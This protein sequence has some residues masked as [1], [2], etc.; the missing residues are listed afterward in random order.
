MKKFLKSRR[1]LALLLCIVVTA[2]AIIQF[3]LL[4]TAAAFPFIFGVVT[5]DGT[6]GAAAAIPAHGSRH[7]Q[8]IGPVRVSIPLT[9]VTN[10]IYQAIPVKKGWKLHGCMWK[11]VTAGA[12]TTIALDFGITGIVATGLD[13]AVDGKSV[14]GTIGFS[15]P[16]DT[17]PALGG[18]NVIADDT[19]DILLNT[20]TAMT[21]APVFDLWL[22][23]EDVDADYTV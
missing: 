1:G 14:A 15:T 7:I 13:A 10:D 9:G 8:R 18:Y 22:Y 21:T 6:G 17:W 19:V 11:M 12:G 16:A 4:G 5:T 2:I 23:V 3:G 20:I